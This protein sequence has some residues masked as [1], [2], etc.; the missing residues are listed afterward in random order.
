MV[1]FDDVSYSY[2]SRPG[3]L[4]NINLRVEKGDFRFIVASTAEYKTTLLNLIYGEILPNSGSVEVL[5][6]RLPGDKKKISRLRSEI[7]YVFS[8]FELFDKL[9]VEQNLA[10]A[11]AIKSRTRQTAESADHIAAA[12]RGFPY[13]DSDSAVSQLSSGEKQVLNFIRALITEPVL[14]L[15]DDP[16][17][18]C[19][20]TETEAFMQLLNEKHNKGMTIVVATSN[21]AIPEE[22]KKP[23]HILKSGRLQDV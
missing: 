12:L 15:A 8:G 7:G 17:R 3:G 20:R 18:H 22:Y 1:R 9:T 6:Y 10:I 5:G 23:Y 2:K 16:F 19:G 4:K 13:I 21:P 11:L 14:L